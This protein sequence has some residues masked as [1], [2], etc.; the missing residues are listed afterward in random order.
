MTMPRTAILVLLL[1]ALAPPFAHAQPAKDR[2]PPDRRVP[3]RA[4][5]RDHD[6]DRYRTPHWVYDYRYN[7]NRHYPAIGYSITV[8][9]APHVALT[10]RGGRLYFHAG[11]WYQLMGG[12]YVVVRPPVGVVLPGPPPAYTLVWVGG[13]PYY[14]A[15][16]VY[17]VEAPGGFAV[18]EP[19]VTGTPA[20]ESSPPPAAAPAPAVEQPPAAAPGGT[21]YYCE[22]AKAYYPYV[23]ECAEGW[24]AV[25]A[26][27]PGQ[28]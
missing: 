13:V 17:Y 6:R 8:L 9:P 28:R 7:H 11:V 2:H 1:L 21:W 5:P 25:P 3:P 14:Y 15:N 22:S 20:P 26:T 16:G 4:D 24:R 12:S 27:P 23:R 10:F 18:A 19:P